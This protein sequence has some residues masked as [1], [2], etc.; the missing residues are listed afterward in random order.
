MCL[1]VLFT[2]PLKARCHYYPTSKEGKSLELHDVL[3]SVSL[4]CFG[5]SCI[6]DGIAIRRL[7]KKLDER[8]CGAY[9]TEQLNSPFDSKE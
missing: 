6:L 8:C 7:E 5:I 1:P 9:E 3:V 4:V 2:Q